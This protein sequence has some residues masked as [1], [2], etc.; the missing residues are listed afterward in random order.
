MAAIY[1]GISGWRGGFY[2]EGLTQKRELHVASRAVHHN[3]HNI[4]PSALAKPAVLL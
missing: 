3:E 1:I 4:E 2:P